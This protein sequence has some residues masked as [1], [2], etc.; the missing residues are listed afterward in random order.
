M[1]AIGIENFPHAAGPMRW[2]F[3]SSTQISAK[4]RRD[5]GV[6]AGLVP[7]LSAMPAHGLIPYDQRWPLSSMGATTGNGEQWQIC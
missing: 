4:Y 6:V 3:T 2:I 7:P 5:H 1:I